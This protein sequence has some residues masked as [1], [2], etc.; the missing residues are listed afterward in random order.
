LEARGDQ[1]SNPLGMQQTHQAAEP[2]FRF[3][4]AGDRI[5]LHERPG[6]HDTVPEDWE[7]LLDFADHVFFGK[8]LKLTY[9]NWPYPEAPKAFSW[10]AP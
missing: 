2:V 1:W 8:A 10:A 6:G 3:L 5:A 9:N 7:A 4:G